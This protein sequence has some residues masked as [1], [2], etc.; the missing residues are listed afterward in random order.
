LE[1]SGELHAPDT[2][3]PGKEPPV[4]IGYEVE[5]V[6]EP[7]CTTWKG[8]ESSTGTQT[9]TLWLYSPYLVAIPTALSWLL[10]IIEMVTK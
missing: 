2:L 6:P 4:F 8:G 5:W 1:V 7:V 3:F 10:N 9:P